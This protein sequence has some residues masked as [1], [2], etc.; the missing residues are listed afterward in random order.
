[1]N[2][3]EEFYFSKQIKSFDVALGFSKY[4]SHIKNTE[5][6]LKIINNLYAIK[7]PVRIFEEDSMEY[8][9]FY[10]SYSKN[11]NNEAIEL[12]DKNHLL[13]LQSKD[14]IYIDKINGLTWDK[15]RNLYEKISEI[16]K[17]NT[18]LLNLVH[19][20]GHSDWR[21]PTIEEIHTITPEIYND[22]NLTKENI[23][24]P[25]NIWSNF[26]NGSDDDG[27]FVR[28]KD[29]RAI[30][31]YFHEGDRNTGEGSKGY[32]YKAMNFAVRSSI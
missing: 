21:I 18:K 31:Q 22:L 10:T 24:Y 32:S 19:F 15:S 8:L 26:V 28:L 1:M 5:I 6:L 14:H 4:L 29:M 25:G 11:I 7:S 9:K 17:T 27:R 16:P 2:L 20:G 12:L 23:N 3:N 13:M 30:G